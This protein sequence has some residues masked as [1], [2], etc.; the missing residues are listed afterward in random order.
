[1]MKVT[2]RLR[3]IRDKF[4]RLYSSLL[5][6]KKIEEAE[7]IKSKTRELTKHIE[8]LSG[9]VMD[10]WIEDAE[11]VSDKLRKANDRILENI[12][13]IKKSEKVAENIV[14]LIGHLDKVLEIAIA[15][16]K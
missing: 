15:L 12:R 2:D 13:E 11:S 10:D 6:Q 16:A 9:Q 8:T 4:E 7:Q 14:K 5:R 3:L 1:M